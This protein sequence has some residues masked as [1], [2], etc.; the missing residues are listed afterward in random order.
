EAAILGAC[1]KLDGVKD[2]V[3][4][5]PRKCDWDPLGL[6][7]AG[8]ETDTCLTAPQVA[9]VRKIF[10]GPTNSK[11]E[12]IYP[13]MMRG[14]MLGGN[15]WT[16]WITGNEPGKS[17]QYAFGVGS[18]AKM[19]YQNPAWDFRT[20]NFDKDVAFLDDKLGPARNATNPDLKKLKDRGGKL[21]IYHGWNDPAVA[22]LN[23][24][25]YYTSVV[26]KMGQKDVD[27]FVRLYMAPGMQHCGGGPGP[28]ILGA[29]PNSSA[30]EFT[31]FAAMT[32][33]VEN[34]KAP[35]KIIAT[36]FKTDNNASSGAVRTRPLCAFPQV[37]RYSGSGSTDDAAS[38]SCVA[39]K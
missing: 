28:N 36:K 31:I 12:Q 32:K 1:D 29:G 24:V 9:A 34:G 16:G 11:G 6:L 14:G 19:V 22:P 4:D 35:E 17:L 3:L 27:S 20:F 5:D 13:G 21:I 38:F 25:N 8:P 26:N 7:C 10:A 30:G 33:W 37:A 15:S 39:P 23:S 2:G 18:V